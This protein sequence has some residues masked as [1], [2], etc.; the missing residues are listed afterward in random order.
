MSSVLGKFKKNNFY[1][2]FDTKLKSIISTFKKAP[3][4]Q[5]YVYIVMLT[6]PLLLMTYQGCETADIHTSSK[7][8]EENYEDESL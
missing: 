3:K 2:M 5:R 8:I 4:A 1:N 7:Q 6:L